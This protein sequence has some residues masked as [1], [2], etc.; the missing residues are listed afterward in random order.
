MKKVL[1][2]NGSISTRKNSFS[3][4]VTQEIIDEYRRLN[5]DDEIIE[6]DLN[7]THAG[8]I[9][10]AHN[11]TEYYNQ[12]D[13]DF[14]IDLL[15]KVDKIII[16][17][18]EINFSVSPVVKNFIDSIMVPKKTFVYK[19]DSSINNPSQGLLNHLSVLIV[20]SRGSHE[21]AYTWA[22]TGEWLK[23][24]WLFLGVPNVQHINIHGT[25]LAE[26][27]NL[28]SEEIKNKHKDEIE[29]VLK[30]F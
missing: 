29:K 14:W 13:S 18:S 17:S 6:Y 30:E 8:A 11:L 25:D 4:I 22:A 19:Q 1:F 21:S 10:H 20:T 16:A 12:V 7:K 9:V 15:A 3:S 26:N 23:N 2:L 5:P 27:K 28:S 24:I